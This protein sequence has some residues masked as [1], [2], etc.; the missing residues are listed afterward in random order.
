MET[1][2]LFTHTQRDNSVSLRDAILGSAFVTWLTLW[3][4][5]IMERELTPMQCLHLLHAQLA[6]GALL[7]LGGTSAV[8]AVLLAAWFG[9]SV[10]Q[11]A[12]ALK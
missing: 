3:T 6:F 9:L 2:I 7:L 1:N 12:R 4:S 10:L 11:C 8:V 5:R